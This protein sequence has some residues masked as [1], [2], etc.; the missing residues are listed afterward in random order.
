M[1]SK[2]PKQPLSIPA[3]HRR[4]GCRPCFRKP[5]FNT[6]FIKKKFTLSSPSYLTTLKSLPP[7]SCHITPFTPLHPIAAS[8][9][10]SFSAA[11]PK[12]VAAER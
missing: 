6:N 11:H 7:K 10:R 8:K 3:H 12:V 5:V 1:E 9:P 2:S 4:L